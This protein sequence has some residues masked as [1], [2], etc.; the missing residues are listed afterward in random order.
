MRRS[1]KLTQN[2]IF[3]DRCIYRVFQ[4]GLNKSK[5]LLLEN[6]LIFLNEIFCKIKKNNGRL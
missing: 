2:P 6:C 4:K 1:Y 5:N 3:I